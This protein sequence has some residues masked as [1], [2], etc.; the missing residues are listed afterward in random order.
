MI[1]MLPRALIAVLL[2]GILPA[3]AQQSQQQKIERILELTNANAVVNEIVNQITG[4]ME[5]IQPN[6]TPQQKARRQEALDKIAKVAGDRMRKIRPEL[7][8]IYS[9]TFTPE[10]IDGILA[11][12]ETPAGKASLAKI[13]TINAK[14]SA[15]VQI[16]MNAA[17]QEINKIA[18]DALKK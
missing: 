5:Q 3:S 10:E 14:L 13:P 16:E 2:F 1:S 8:Q 7:V 12:Y 9:E 15:L 4:W 6:P 18:E 11:F 17:G